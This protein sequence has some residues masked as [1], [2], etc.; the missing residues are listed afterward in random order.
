MVLSIPGVVVCG[1]LLAL[2]LFLGSPVIIALFASLPF[3][4]TA[5]GELPAVGGSTPQIYAVMGVLFCA[6]VMARRDF[7]RQLSFVFASYWVSWIISALVLH[8]V[9]S[10]FI[11]PRL[12]AGATSALVP[13]RGTITELPLAPV[14]G[15]ITQPAYFTLSALSFFGFC[16]VLRTSSN[17]AVVRRGFFTCVI[18]HATLGIFDLGG[19]LVGA[20][21]VLAPIRTASYSLLTEVELA[22]FWRV[23]GGF[24]EASSFGVAT[25]SFLAFTFAYWRM[26][27]SRPALVL[28]LVLSI[29]LIAS[30]SSIA[31][32]GGAVLIIYLM[33][34]IAYSSLI[35]RMKTQDGLLLLFGAAGLVV[36]ASLYIYDANLFDPVVD[37]VETT[38][39]DKPSSASALER[40]Y[41]NYRSLQSVLETGGVGIG[42]GSSRASSWPIAVLSQLGVVGALLMGVLVFVILRGTGSR[43]LAN[44]DRELLALA[45]GSRAAVLSSLIALSLVGSGADPGVLFFIGLAII[46]TCRYRLSATPASRSF[47]K[48]YAPSS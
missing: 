32:A 11:L 14:S 7:P 4:S 45:A 33:A 1:A 20:G 31:Y 19:K 28:T 16:I 17:I 6:V 10:A 47:K 34:A 40:S 18:V 22:G 2:G 39:L 3:G 43:K 37:L 23:A 26:S 8:A 27:N 48:L 38:L 5:I 30:T 15:N 29:L 35:G 44:A 36:L 9:A 12:F 25:L 46:V 13:V 21:D 24:P 41:W 42:L